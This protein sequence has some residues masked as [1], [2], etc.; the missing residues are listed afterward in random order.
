MAI[1]SSAQDLYLDL[2]SGVTPD[3]DQETYVVLGIKPGLVFARQVPDLYS[4]SQ[5]AGF[6]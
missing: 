3:R 2:W 5:G 4:N 1:P 6:F